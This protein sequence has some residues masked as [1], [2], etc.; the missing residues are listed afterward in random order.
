M[1]GP[2]LLLLQSCM[3]MKLRNIHDEA[4]WLLVHCMNLL[5]FANCMLF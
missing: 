5:V 1:R 4:P 2:F 3:Q